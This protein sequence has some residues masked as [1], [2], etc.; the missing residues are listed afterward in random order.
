MKLNAKFYVIFH[1]VGLFVSETLRLSSGWLQE[2]LHWSQFPKETHKEPY[3]TVSLQQKQETGKNTKQI[4]ISPEFPENIV[5]K[6]I[7][8]TE[9]FCE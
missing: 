1:L 4:W 5:S 8:E 7:I 6:Y 3:G 2:T 9:N